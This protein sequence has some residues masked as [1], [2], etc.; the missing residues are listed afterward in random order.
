MNVSELQELTFQHL[1][2]CTHFVAIL[3]DHGFDDLVLKQL[4]AQM[5]NFV[6]NGWKPKKKKLKHLAKVALSN[7]IFKLYIFPL[8]DWVGEGLRGGLGPSCKG[9]SS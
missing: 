6:D 3:L 5:F 4:L 9:Q 8:Q 2:G 7:D 1:D